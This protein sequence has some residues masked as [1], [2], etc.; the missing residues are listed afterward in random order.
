MG[1]K[2]KADTSGEA[3]SL[4]LM[5]AF[6]V[7]M[8]AYKA[9]MRGI[10]SEVSSAESTP[11]RVMVVIVLRKHGALPMG[12]IASYVGLPK[13]NITALVDDLEAEGVLRRRRDE[14]DRRIMHVELTPKGRALCAREYDAYVHSLASIFDVLPEGE[15]DAMLAGLE[16]MTRMLREGSAESEA[17]E[18]PAAPK[19][20]RSKARPRG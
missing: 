19:L 15:R 7:F 17:T 1:S 3:N 6:S 9:R 20:G 5:D 10:L 8:H 14:A 4:A 18:A 2:T 12:S 13:S 16:R 11:S